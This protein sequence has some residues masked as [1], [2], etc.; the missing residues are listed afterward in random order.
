MDTIP[1][2]TMVTITTDGK[3]QDDQNWKNHIIV[4]NYVDIDECLSNHG[5]TYISYS[6]GWTGYVYVDSKPCTLEN[7]IFTYCQ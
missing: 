5:N 4:L 1:T 3:C 2:N 7:P 6:C